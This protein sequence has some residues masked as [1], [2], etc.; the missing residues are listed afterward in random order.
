MRS[1]LP[2]LLGISLL[3]F[4]LGVA[5]CATQPAGIDRVKEFRL[6]N[7]EYGNISPGLVRSQ[8]A[9]ILYGAMTTREKVDRLGQYYTVYWNDAT[10]EVPVE[11]VF[12]YQQAATGSKV[13]VRKMDY[14]AGRKGGEVESHFDFIGAEYRK[15]GTVMAWSVS[16]IRDGKVLSRKTSYLWR[17]DTRS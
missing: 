15:M 12:E 14:P 10:P 8:T 16:L 6:I 17:D 7:T 11:L 3:A 9:S 13:F 5:A 1:A 4:I 2:V